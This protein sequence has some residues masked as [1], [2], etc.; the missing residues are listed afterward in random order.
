[1]VFFLFNN[2][3]IYSVLHSDKFKKYIGSAMGIESYENLTIEIDETESEID[4]QITTLNL[5][6]TSDKEKFGFVVEFNAITSDYSITSSTDLSLEKINQGK[7][8]FDVSYWSYNITYNQLANMFDKNRIKVPDMQRGFVWNETQASRLIE[9][10]VMGLPLPSIFLVAIEENSKKQ[11]LIIDGLQRITSIFS[12]IFNKKLPNSNSKSDGFS[13]KGVNKAFEGRKYDDLVREGLSDNLEFNTI[14]VIE[15]NQ[16][17]PYNESAMYSIFERLNS[18]GTSLTDQQIRNSIYY[19]Y[20]NTKL[21]EFSKNKLS[22]YFPHSQ[23]L[24]LKNSEMMLRVIMVYH[25]F[26]NERETG[27]NRTGTLAYKNAMNRISEEYHIQYKKAELMDTLDVYK[28][29][30]DDLFR[31]ISEGLQSIEAILNEVSF[32]KYDSIKRDFTGRISPI[33]FEALMVSYLLNKELSFKNIGMEERYKSI[34]TEVDPVTEMTQ[35]ERYFK[36]GTGQRENIFQRVRCMK[37]V[38][39]DVG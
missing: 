5:I 19:G 4:N 15:F 8:K 22:K 38:L 26:N 30:V 25:L 7:T 33:L 27:F 16:S 21:N 39:F 9:S 20:F 23:I 34:F 3:D 13:L 6:A 1:M 18:G 17:K 24:A 29:K 12:F 31:D 32:K 36:Q 28:S 10:I 35:F 2:E 14:N 11:Y 37:K